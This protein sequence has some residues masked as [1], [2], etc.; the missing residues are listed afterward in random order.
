[1]AEGVRVE[2]LLKRADFIAA[3]KGRRRSTPAFLLQIR[4]TEL[5]V[6]RVGFTV[7]KKIGNAVARN[8]IKRR[9]RAVVS[10]VMPNHA[11]PG[12][13]YVLIARQAALTRPYPLLLDDLRGALVDPRNP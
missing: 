5:E 7:T 8:R 12:A 9:L 13:D 11:V 6:A 1:M 10:E 2:R 4:P 3:R